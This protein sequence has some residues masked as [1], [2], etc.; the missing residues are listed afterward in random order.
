MKVLGPNGK[1]SI[2]QAGVRKFVQEADITTAGN[3][4][5]LAVD[6]LVVITAS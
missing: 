1:K 5:E 2:Q 4:G 3:A 6:Q